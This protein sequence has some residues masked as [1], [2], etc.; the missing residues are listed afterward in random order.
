MRQN[1]V[2]VQ[3]STRVKETM[4]KFPAVFWSIDVAKRK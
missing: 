4:V 2:N 3:S 1:F